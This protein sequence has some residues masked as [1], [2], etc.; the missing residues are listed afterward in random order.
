MI[1]L[2]LAW[3]AG[4]EVAVQMEKADP[5]Q[6]VQI[7]QISRRTRRVRQLD[8]LPKKRK[9]MSECIHLR[10]A[11]V[12]EQCN[13][14]P[15]NLAHLIQSGCRREAPQGPKGSR[16]N[17]GAEAIPYG[18]RALNYLHGRLAARF[19]MAGFSRPVP[20][21]STKIKSTTTRRPW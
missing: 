16:Q 2:S 21:F 10:K 11:M 3:R 17:T 20:G 4:L 9:A 7:V 5:V 8:R 15:S 13:E 1:S 18:S 14:W 12:L 19:R 6:I